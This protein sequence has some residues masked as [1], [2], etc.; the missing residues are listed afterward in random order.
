MIRV[1]GENAAECVEK[2]FASARGISLRAADINRVLYGKILEEDVIVCRTAEHSVEIHSHG[3]P[4]AMRRIAELLAAH[5]AGEIDREE[6]LE[7]NYEDVIQRTA[8]GMLPHATT[9]RAT[10]ILLDQMNGALRKAFMEIETAEDDTRREELLAEL[11]RRRDVARHLITPWRVV[12]AGKP[13]VGKSSLFNAV[14]G[15]S[16]VLVH[17]ESGTTRDVVRETVTLDGWNFE[18]VDTAGLNAET[19]DE[20]EKEGIRRA[21]SVL[22]DA[23]LILHVRDAADFE[24]EVGGYLNE[25]GGLCAVVLNVWNKSDLRET[26]PA[27]FPEDA[28]FVSA[29]EAESVVRLCE[30]IL[31]M[32]I[33]EPPAPGTA[34]PICEI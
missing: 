34:I 5:G 3:S 14:M 31:Q 6:Y 7:E 15:F 2:V 17:E 27:E 1:L 20:V 29:K 32:L 25:V 24:A 23:D 9:W 13:N 19:R 10:R 11:A 30:K 21:I 28:I 26:L 33:P 22:E 8:A 12:L 16:R 4:V 18:F